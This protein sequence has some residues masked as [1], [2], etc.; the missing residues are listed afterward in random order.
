MLVKLGLVAVVKAIGKGILFP[1]A[2]GE[3]QVAAPMGSP[4]SSS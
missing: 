1:K 3:C 4:S 2:S